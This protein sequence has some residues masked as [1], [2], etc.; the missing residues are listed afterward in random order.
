MEGGDKVILHPFIL[1]K[2]HERMNHGPLTFSLKG[3]SMKR[4]TH[5]GVLEFSSPDPTIA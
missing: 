4:K 5:V 1:A 2:L 3:P